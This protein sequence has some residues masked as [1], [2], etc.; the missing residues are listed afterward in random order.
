MLDIVSDTSVNDG[1]ALS[2]AFYF[3]SVFQRGSAILQL[4]FTFSS[5][6][7]ISDTWQIQCK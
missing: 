5:D 3:F 6:E 1:V 7:E 4:Y 2:L